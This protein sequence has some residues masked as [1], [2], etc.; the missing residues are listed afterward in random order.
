M[1]SSCCTRRAEAASIPYRQPCRKPSLEPGSAPGSSFCRGHPE[2]GTSQPAGRS[3]SPSHVHGFSPRSSLP[4]FTC[5]SCT[6]GARQ[7]QNPPEALVPYVRPPLGRVV[8]SKDNLLKRRYFHLG[9]ALVNPEPCV[10]HRSCGDG[11]EA[12]MLR[13]GWG[14]ASAASQDWCWKLWFGELQLM[15]VPPPPSLPVVCKDQFGWFRILAQFAARSGLLSSFGC[16]VSIS[17]QA[18]RGEMFVGLTF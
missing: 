7:Q 15:E 13:H 8:L 5:Q 11:R 6:V 12:A 2:A 18:C 14:T 1:G 9:P 4:C 17:R 10:C 3:S 16:S